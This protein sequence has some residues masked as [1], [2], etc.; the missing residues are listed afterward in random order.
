MPNQFNMPI[1]G[2]SLTDTPKNARW[3]RPPEMVDPVQIVEYYVKKLSDEELLQDISVVFQLGGDLKTFTESLMLL[4][5]AE[6]LHTVEAGIVVAPVVGTLIKLAMED[7]GVEVRETNVDYEK[8]ATERENKRIKL[9][10]MDAIKQDAQEDGKSSGVLEQISG[11][12]EGGE[13]PQETEAP[14]EEPEMNEET[15]PAPQGMGLMAK[16]NM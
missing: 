15:S 16:G 14:T 13:E 9:L 3:E 6:G 1:P 10:I 12:M 11:E 7:L 8:A 5:T 4:G 2:Q